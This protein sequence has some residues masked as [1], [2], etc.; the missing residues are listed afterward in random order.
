MEEWTAESGWPVGLNKVFRMAF[1]FHVRVKDSLN[2]VR[3]A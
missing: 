2:Q 1:G 3:H